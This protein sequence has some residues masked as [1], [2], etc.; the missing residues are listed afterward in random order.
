MEIDEESRMS[1]V[2]AVL[3]GVA[4]LL[5]LVLIIFGLWALGGA[6]YSAW[7]LFK[8]PDGISYFAKYFLDTTKLAAQLPKGG[9]GVAHYVS[10][11][12][13]ILLLLVLGKLGIWA[14][15][16]GAKLLEFRIKRRVWHNE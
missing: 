8:D 13:V 4:A 6:I 3:A 15:T 7:G 14:V 1:P 16:A 11:F 12:A 2:L 9:E 5:G 10:W